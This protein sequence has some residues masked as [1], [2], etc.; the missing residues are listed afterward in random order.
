MLNDRAYRAYQVS[1]YAG[2]APR[3]HQPGECDRRGR[4]TPGGRA[5]AVRAAQPRRRQ[6]EAEAVAAPAKKLL[7][8]CWAMLRDGR[9]WQEQPT[10]AVALGVLPPRPR[11]GRTPVVRA[12]GA[13]ARGSAQ[14]CRGTVALT[15]ARS[16]VPALRTARRH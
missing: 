4:I 3:Q 15:T 14:P 8:R 1:A 6:E 10:T 16:G 7:V 12:S 13:D 2:L 5:R 9:D 11:S